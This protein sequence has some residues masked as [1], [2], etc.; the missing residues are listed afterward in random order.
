[1]PAPITTA[2]QLGV[3]EL[4]EL[5]APLELELLVELGLPLEPAALELSLEPLA[6]E[7]LLELLGAGALGT[8]GREAGCDLRGWGTGQKP[9]APT[10]SANTFVNWLS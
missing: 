3:E 5:G 4:V 10:G 8:G 1:M 2:S 7:L 6:L 9:P